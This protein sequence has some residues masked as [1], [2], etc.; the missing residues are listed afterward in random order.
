MFSGLLD[1]IQRFFDLFIWWT[2]VQP[3][4]Q[5]IR[6]RLG[7]ARKRL[8]PGI[9][10]KIPY[11]DAIFKQPT[12][13]LY[14]NFGPISVTTADSQTLTLSGALGY[15]VRDLDTLYDKLQHAEDGIH[16]IVAGA[17]TEFVASHPLSDCTPTHIVEGARR[18]LRLRRFGLSVAQLT[19]TSYAKVRVI[20][21]I[22]DAD[23]SSKW[24]DSLDTESHHT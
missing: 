8:P 16:A 17:V 10:F 7:K 18:L 4:E 3:W 20:R 11:A 22:T 21:L 19:L 24:G 1:F 5:G 14:T 13:R 9:H 15:V 12:R 2:V 6:V 23:T